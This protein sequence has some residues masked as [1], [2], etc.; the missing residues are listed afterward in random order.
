MERFATINARIAHERCRVSEKALP[1]APIPM[2]RAVSPAVRQLDWKDRYGC[3]ETRRQ[4]ALP[5][6]SYAVHKPHESYAE[7]A[8]RG[9]SCLG[10]RERCAQSWAWAAYRPHEAAR[11]AGPASIEANHPAGA[12]RR[13]AQQ[14][15]LAAKSRD[16][17]DAAQASSAK[18]SL[19]RCSRGTGAAWPRRPQMS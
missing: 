19:R 14:P 8:H 18:G 11:T 1:A 12:T 2:R 17:I 15:K 3:Q 7:L 9:T 6:L 16:A 13:D 5:K 10:L 4:S